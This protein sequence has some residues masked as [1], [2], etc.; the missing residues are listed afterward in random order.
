MARARLLSVAAEGPAGPA[1][2][3]ACPRGGGWGQEPC[4]LEPSALSGDRA[5][6]PA[7]SWNTR[8]GGDT[9]VLA[10][11]LRPLAL[12]VD[13]GTLARG[14]AAAPREAADAVGGRG[15]QATATFPLGLPRVDS[16]S[17]LNSDGRAVDFG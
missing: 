8:G 9:R 12:A 14:G 1:V 10:S 15:W 13:Q 11:A 3:P 6:V 17:S 16:A 5:R 4:Q 2:E 7:R